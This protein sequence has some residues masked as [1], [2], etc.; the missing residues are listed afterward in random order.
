MM[1]KEVEMD[2][3]KHSVNVCNVFGGVE[4]AAKAARVSRMGKQ[5]SELDDVELVRKL[6]GWGH[7]TPLEF[8]SL[9]F[10]VTTSRSIAN[11]LTRHRMASF[12][13]ES[14]RYVSYA[15][16]CAEYILPYWYRNRTGR[17]E[18]MLYAAVNFAEHAY[19]DMVDNGIAPE[20]ARDVMPLCLSTRVYVCMN[21]RSFL[22]FLKLRLDAAAHTE[23][24]ILARKMLNAVLA[25]GCN[26]VF[27]ESIDVSSTDGL[28]EE[29]D[30]IQA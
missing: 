11:E 7:L 21:M 14:T 4:E 12:V 10:K 24:R 13:Q 18:A 22:N 20:F 15:G 9:Q 29:Y 26:P 5:A 27:F 6:I 25:E 30:A 19:R 17:N 28:V 3:I 16:D 8:C 1:Y 23:M 2:F